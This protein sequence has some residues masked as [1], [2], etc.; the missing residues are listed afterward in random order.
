MLLK[1][2]SLL[3]YSKLFKL[4]NKIKYTEST[5]CSHLYEQKTQY[6]HKIRNDYSTV[7]AGK[8]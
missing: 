8:L 1:N 7:V 4:D 6:Y 3:N 2:Y 5:L